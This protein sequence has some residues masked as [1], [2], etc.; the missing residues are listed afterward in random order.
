MRT[1]A[2]F[3]GVPVCF[4]Y[5][6]KGGCRRAAPGANVCKDGNTTFAHVCNF[7]IKGTGGKADAHCLGPHSRVGNH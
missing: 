2:R 3:N 5:N 1:P 7:Y 6:N 4:G